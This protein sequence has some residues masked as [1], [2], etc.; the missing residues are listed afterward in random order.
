MCDWGGNR[1]IFFFFPSSCPH[2]PSLPHTHTHMQHPQHHH[3]CPTEDHDAAHL[4]CQSSHFR[5]RGNVSQDGSCERPLS[6][7][8]CPPPGTGTASPR[9]QCR[10]HW[11]GKKKGVRRWWGG[12]GEEGGGGNSGATVFFPSS[13]SFNYGSVVLSGLPR[14]LSAVNQRPGTRAGGREGGRKQEQSVK[15]TFCTF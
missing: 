10:W 8:L 3:W 5:C 6:Q 7:G 1:E 11:R 4:V 12:R 14:S 2:P 13:F 15:S 9:W